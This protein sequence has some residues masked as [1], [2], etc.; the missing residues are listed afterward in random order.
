MNAYKPLVAE[1][2]SSLTPRAA[3]GGTLAPSRVIDNEFGSERTTRGGERIMGGAEEKGLGPTKEPSA[4]RVAAATDFTKSSCGDNDELISQ[5]YL[6]GRSDM[7]ES[8]CHMAPRA[9]SRS[10][11]PH[12]SSR[13]PS[14]SMRPFKDRSAPFGV[15]PSPFR[16]RALEPQD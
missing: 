13:M 3:T 6:R 16:S 7:R 9:V 14:S 12:S 4:E 5:R 1:E 10:S 15:I 11:V 8:R 2:M